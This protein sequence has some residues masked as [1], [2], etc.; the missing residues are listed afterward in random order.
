MSYDPPLR[1]TWTYDGLYD[2]AYKIA[3]D[4]GYH[5]AKT[6]GLEIENPYPDLV[7]VKPAD[8]FYD[9]SHWW[10]VGYDDAL[11]VRNE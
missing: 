2:H 5:H 1:R 4:E 10:C 3:Y 11:G 8:Y 6:N 7:H 9:L